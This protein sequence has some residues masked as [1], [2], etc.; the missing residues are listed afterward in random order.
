VSDGPKKPEGR[1]GFAKNIGLGKER[2]ALL[3][4]G[5]RPDAAD[6]GLAGG[7]LQDAAA[8]LDQVE[9]RI[10]AKAR[11]WERKWASMII[12][13]VLGSATRPEIG[14][15]GAALAT[16]CRAML[17]RLF[18][19]DAAE[20][21][22]LH[23]RLSRG[24]Y[25]PADYRRDLAAMPPYEW[26][27]FT[28]RLLDIDVVP[29]REWERQTDMNVYLGSGVETILELIDELEPA[30]VLYDLGSGLGKVTL[31]VA[32]LS[33]VRAKGVEFEPAYHQRAIER[34]ARLPSIGVEYIQ[35]DARDLDY[36]DGSVFYLYDSFRGEIRDA[37]AA[38]MEIVS[39]SR[40]IKFLTAHY[41]TPYARE[42]PWLEE[43]RVRP[44]GLAVF[45]SRS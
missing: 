12:K 23:G 18:A 29:E 5:I 6:G 25:T 15:K 35:A 26:N 37:V 19:I 45:R 32:W 13:G 22:E 14:E 3:A 31:L 20:F 1:T 28:D 24:E 16:R 44:S 8:Q 30:D 7:H 17:E 11:L 33:G 9:G 34:A 4:R 36:L 21:K 39:R 43:L 10:S 2:G 38:K 27:A 42:L 41:A 40:P